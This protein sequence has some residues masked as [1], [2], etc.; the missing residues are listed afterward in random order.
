LENEIWRTAS[1]MRRRIHERDSRGNNTQGAQTD[2][3]LLRQ[4][5]GHRGGEV[6]RGWGFSDHPHFAHLEPGNE[7]YAGSAAVVSKD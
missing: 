6:K 1:G 5:D 3:A 2:K 7:G 4:R